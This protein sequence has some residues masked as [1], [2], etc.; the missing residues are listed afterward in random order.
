MNSFTVHPLGD[1]ALL[2]QFTSM[3]DSLLLS[4][5]HSLTEKLLRLKLDGIVDIVPA[6]QSIAIYYDPMHYSFKDLV[7]T[8]N[9]NI[10]EPVQNLQKESKLVSIPVCY[11]E[12]LGLDI[13]EISNQRN[14]S[15]EDI[16]QLHTRV[17]YTVAIMGFLPGFPYLIG[18]HKQL[19]TPRKS[20]P[21][22]HVPKG[23][24]AI[25]SSYT[26]IYPFSSP[27][28]WNIIGQTPISLFDSQK[29]DP[30]LLLPGDQIQFYSISKEEFL[31]WRHNDDTN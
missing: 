9:R 21:R 25:G 15:V 1:N 24:V 27:G 20:T 12:T 5:I 17:T 29:A 18:L 8:L 22:I 11:D 26:G 13:M 4:H 31:S 6:F 10:L 23:A 16:I 14:L 30:F 2:L 28:G 19:F 3:N 7:L